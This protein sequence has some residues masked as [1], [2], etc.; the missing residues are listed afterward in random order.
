MKPMDEWTSAETREELMEEI[1]EALE[2]I[3]GITVEITQP[4]QMRFNELMSGIRRM[5]QSKP[6]DIEVL[7]AEAEE[8][9]K[10]IRNVEG[11]NRP[12]VEQVTGLPQIIVSYDRD[13]I[14]Q[15]GL[16]I[17]DVNTIP[18]LLLPATWV[19]SLKAKSDSI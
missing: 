10:A 16:T 4:M 14:A 13:K 19:S 3:P 15:Y 1:E 8:V 18:E 2:I 11:V 5:W 9:A 17:S 12:I 6:D 7:Q